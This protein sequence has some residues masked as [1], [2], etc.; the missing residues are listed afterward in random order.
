MLRQTYKLSPANSRALVN[1]A[2]LEQCEPE[3]ILHGV[4]RDMLLRAARHYGTTFPKLAA[5]Q[6]ELTL[7]R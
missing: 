4:V 1:L 6:L 5:E 3:H 2:R 7:V